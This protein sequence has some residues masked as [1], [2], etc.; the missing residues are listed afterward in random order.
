M[1]LENFSF[2]E[3]K[4]KNIIDILKLKGMGKEMPMLSLPF[5][6]WFN[7]FDFKEFNFLEFGSGYSTIYFSKIVKSVTSYETDEDFYKFMLNKN[8]KSIDYKLIDTKKIILGEFDMPT[9]K[10]LIV[11][12]DCDFNRYHVCK[13]ILIKSNPEIIIL[14]NS[15]WYPEACSILYEKEYNEIPFWGIRPEENYEKCTSVFLKKDF[16]LP[17]KNINFFSQGAKITKAPNE[18]IPA[19]ILAIVLNNS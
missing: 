3:D 19:D 5:L 4:Q 16:L 9:E 2:D 13:N 10:K 11:L 15:E 7:S 12:I 18:T 17:K 8:L 14:D 1:H 6:D